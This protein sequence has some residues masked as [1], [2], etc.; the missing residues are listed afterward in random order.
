MTEQVT[1]A[2]VEEQAGPVFPDEMAEMAFRQLEKLINDRN[3]EVG[4][5]N[6]VKGDRQTLTEQ[7]EE[8]STSPAAVDARKR[9]DA[10][11]AALDEAIMDLHKAVQPEVDSLLA[12]AEGS[13]KDIEEKVKEMDS[14][15]KP[16][17]NYF[18]KLTSEELAKHLPPL[19]R[20]KG[21]STKGA[22]STGRRV[23]GYDVAVSIDGEVTGFENLASAAKFLDVETAVLQEKFFEAAGNPAKLADA[24][25]RVDFTVAYVETYDDGSTEDK[26]AQVV[27]ERSKSEA[28]ESE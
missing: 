11:Q 26:E 19:Q 22:G 17:I 15:I 1:E 21:F 10:A 28:T 12:N 25:D 8:N 14:T 23:R 7:L 3:A 24:P 9:R 4:K 5:I 16:G 18:K 27:A 6:A 2:Q 13:V 20:L